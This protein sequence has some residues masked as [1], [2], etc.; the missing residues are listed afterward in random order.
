VLNVSNHADSLSESG[1]E[2]KT[3]GEKLALEPLEINGITA[4]I[5]GTIVWTVATV[6]MILMRDQLEASGRG[7]WIWICA[8]G[9]L[10]GLLGIRY[11]RRRAA[12][13]A[14]SSAS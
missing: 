14:K 8:C 12:R 2:A 9:V 7:N 13:I 1:K 6:I 11:T 5:V 4:V 10:L 3:N